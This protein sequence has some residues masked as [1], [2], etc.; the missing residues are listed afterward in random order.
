MK[1]LLVCLYVPL[2][3]EECTFCTRLRTPA[4]IAMVERYADALLREIDSVAP[5]APEGT[6]RAIRFAG[7]VPLMLAGHNVARIVN[8]LRQRFC[9]ADEVEL[10]I[11]T[12]PGK[13]DEHN[14]RLFDT[15]GVNRVEFL[16]PA[17]STQEHHRFRAPGDFG[18]IHENNAM[19]RAFGI[20]DWSLRLVYGAPGQTVELWERTLR[21]ACSM[22]PPH[23]AL[24]NVGFVPREEAFALYQQAAC[25]LEEAGYRRYAG[26]RFALPGGACRFEE[27]LLEGADVLGFGAG[28][29]SFLDGFSYR[30]CA[31]VSFYVEHA[32]DAGAIVRDPVAFGE[33]SL[34]WK[35]VCDRLMTA[36]GFALEEYER[37]FVEPVGRDVCEALDE[38]VC[39][40]LA[41]S[42]RGT[43]GSGLVVRLTDRGVFA[44]DEVAAFLDCA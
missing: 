8:R 18:Q 20:D 41:V 17:G 6:V 28:A 9:V 23:V 13:I 2:C 27:L 44:A 40:G 30:N 1:E 26:Q 36:E 22:E 4:T 33:T 16:L 34:R 42:R 31:D 24:E 11:E 5:D 12:V 39:E 3:N 35:F 14:F 7:G 10:T 37:A 21:E 29:V 15:L 19:R 38:L 43:D 32:E 25:A